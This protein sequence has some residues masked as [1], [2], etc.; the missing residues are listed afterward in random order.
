MP[1]EEEKSSHPLGNLPFPKDPPFPGPKPPEDLS[2]AGEKVSEIPGA[3]KVLATRLNRSVEELNDA[4]S[5]GGKKKP[6]ESASE[7]ESATD[8]V[9]KALGMAAEDMSEEER[10]EAM[11]LIKKKVEEETEE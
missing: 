5:S 4:F 7:A 6:N 9:V 8:L 2:E 10:E 3:V 1:D 11:K